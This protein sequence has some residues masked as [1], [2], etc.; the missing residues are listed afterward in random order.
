MSILDHEKLAEAMATTFQLCTGIEIST[1]LHTPHK[2]LYDGAMTWK[3]TLT[4][5]SYQLSISFLNNKSGEK[6]IGLALVNPDLIDL[7]DSHTK[8]LI[9]SDY[10]ESRVEW[11][12]E[13]MGKND[14]T[15]LHEIMT[16]LANKLKEIKE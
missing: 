4:E 16:D 9:I 14:W 6:C 15:A 13:E 10:Y 2:S 3:A 1:D 11:W 8:G 12:D 7:G 5:S